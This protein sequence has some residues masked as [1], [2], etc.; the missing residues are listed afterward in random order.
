MSP[1]KVGLVFTHKAMATARNEQHRYGQHYTP[2]EVARLLAAF[3]V[4]SASDLVFDPSCGDGRLLVEALSLK[5][6]LARG[7]KRRLIAAEVYGADRSRQAIE[8]AAQTGAQVGAADFFNIAPGA[9]FK[10]FVLPPAFD[11]VIGNPPYIRQE[12]M[13]ARDKQRI[14]RRLIADR[15][16]SEAIHW[17]RWSGRSDIYVY[18]FAHAT[19]FLKPGGR[20]VFLTASSWLD[21]GYGAALREFL[22]ANFRVITV[23]ESSCESFFE[24]ASIN[25]AITV[26]E[27][28]PDES[29]RS[30][31]VIRFVRLTAPLSKV[32]APASSHSKRNRGHEIR[33]FARGLERECDSMTCDDYRI[34]VVAQSQLMSALPSAASMGG[35]PWPPL[36][37]EPNR[38]VK[39]REPRVVSGN[40]AYPDRSGHG[41]PPLQGW[42]K[43]LRAEDIFFRILERGG[44]RLHPL[45][46]IARVRFGVKT[47]AN[48]FFYL[49]DS[50]SAKGEEHREKDEE[51]RST[52]NSLRALG[53]IASVRRGLTTG[54]NEFFYLAQNGAGSSATTPNS[55]RPFP[56][57]EP[58]YLS[59]VIFSLKEIPGILLDSAQ[60]RKL[61]FNCHL[62]RDE[63]E[64]TGALD[65]IRRGEHAGIHKRPTCAS[66]EPWYSLARDR[67]PAP[68]IFPSKVGE[69]WV[70]AV[71]QAGVF[72]D[73]KL[74]GIFPASGVSKLVL[75][76][77][78]NSTWARYYAEI[79]C[80]QMTGAQ[81]IADIDVVIAEQIMIPDPRQLSIGLRTKLEA[82]LK[83]LVRRPIGS[84][85][86]EVEREDRRK[87][88]ELTLE[89]MGFKQRADRLVA[90][91]DL[92]RAVTQLVRLR[93]SKDT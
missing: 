56:I 45:S 25:T 36:I 41:G 92:H 54:A 30:R 15:A 1:R 16:H 48:D 78:L 47:G 61:F 57:I 32:I 11:A 67:R 6:D 63:L 19:R 21:V 7:R 81:A 68:L 49:S 84:V 8:I 9:V 83:R 66:R 12:L 44:A 38:I 80:R 40:N 46:E 37:A 43:F 76:A 88:D 26:L 82:S 2:R 71:N 39:R 31:N 90:L 28:E 55:Q 52:G 5:R 3:A 77:L 74:Y 24:E 91:D 50:Q 58:E 53:E 42:G 86:E 14:G 85:F 87:L 65:Y 64:G 59:P 89:A 60:T 13:S 4:R 33:H 23:I 79:T 29:A 73:K 51:Q 27:R 17:P 22:L 34:R 18:F 75:A 93:L 72:E 62:C 20:L 70:V 69:R 35:S 10:S